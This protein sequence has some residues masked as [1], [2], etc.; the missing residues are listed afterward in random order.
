MDTQRL[1]VGSE[2]HMTMAETMQLADMFV[3][4]AMFPD[5]KTQ[6]QAFVIIMAGR[7]LGFSATASMMG[8]N[9]L[10]GRPSLSADLIAALIKRDRRYGF[11]VVTHTAN[12]CCIQFYEYGKLCH[13]ETY[14]IKDAQTAGLMDKNKLWD[15]YPREF[16]YAR[17][18]SKGGN[19][20]CP[21][22]MAGVDISEEM[23]APIEAVKATRE[24]ANKAVEELTGE[25]HTE[26]PSP[27][28]QTLKAM[29]FQTYIADKTVL[30]RFWGWV[31]SLGLTEDDAHAA[32][33]VASIKDA[34]GTV[35]QVRAVIDAYAKQMAASTRVKEKA[36]EAQGEAAPGY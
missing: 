36:E 22:R 13:T 35:A 24:A 5:V 25:V 19:I 10:F 12:E 7:E 14:T 17:C 9:V 33:N 32:L 11:N 16:L 2:R 6:A 20:V 8:I 34:T 18:I 27:E 29:A 23:S 21:Q 26:E 4:S 28:I 15:K 3:K 31:K 1:G 30:G